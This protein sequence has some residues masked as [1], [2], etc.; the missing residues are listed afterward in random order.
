M[1]N[2]EQNPTEIIEANGSQ[3]RMAEGNIQDFYFF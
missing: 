1:V 2:V 3:W